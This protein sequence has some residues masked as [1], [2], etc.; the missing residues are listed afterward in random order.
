M[1]REYVCSTQLHIA[2]IFQNRRMV[3]CCRRRRQTWGE[4]FQFLNVTHLQAALS[5]RGR[6]P[7]LR[8]GRDVSLRGAAW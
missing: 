6:A 3:R 4:I 1:E 7:F 5:H 2:K 8:T